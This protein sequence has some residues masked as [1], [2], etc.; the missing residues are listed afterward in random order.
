MKNLHKMQLH[1][2]GS[3]GAGGITTKTA[4]YGASR[5]SMKT[6]AT[7]AAKL[8]PAGTGGHEKD[9][10]DQDSLSCE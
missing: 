8:R 2:I 10:P 9:R 7:A 4:A 1:P 6:A 5:T 3:H